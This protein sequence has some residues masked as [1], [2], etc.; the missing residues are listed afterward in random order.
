M[1]I[2]SSSVISNNTKIHPSVNVGPFCIIGDDVE[3][4]EGTSVLSHAIIKGPT[5]IGKNNTC[6]LYTSPSPRDI[7]GSRMPSSA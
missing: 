5:I 3:I 2:D 4:K 7:S 6:L 1:T